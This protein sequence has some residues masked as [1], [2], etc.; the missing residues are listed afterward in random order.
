MQSTDPAKAEGE[1][2]DEELGTT[3]SNQC[4]QNQHLVSH[5]MIFGEM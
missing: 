5:F 2:D 3:K 1:E 4:S